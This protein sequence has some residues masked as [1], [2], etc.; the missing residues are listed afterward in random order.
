MVFII[1]YLTYVI[2]FVRLGHVVIVIW[3]NK[4]APN[5]LRRVKL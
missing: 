1:H 3:A 2:R 4:H 5:V